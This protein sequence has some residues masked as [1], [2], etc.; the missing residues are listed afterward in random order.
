M[1]VE[2]KVKHSFCTQRRNNGSRHY[3]TRSP[4]WPKGRPLLAASA[5]KANLSTFPPAGRAEISKSVSVE[6]CCQAEWIVLNF[7]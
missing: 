4:S 7:Q 2:F 6:T 3:H 1:L 5:E